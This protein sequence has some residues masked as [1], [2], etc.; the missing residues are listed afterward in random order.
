MKSKTFVVAALTALLAACSG[1]ENPEPRSGGLV[2]AASALTES[3]Q[4][5]QVSIVVTPGGY[6]SNLTYSSADGQFH[7]ALLLPVG[8]YN[9]DATAYADTNYD[10]VL[11]PVGYGSAPVVIF[12]TSTTAVALRL[13]DVTGPPPV[14]DHSPVITSATVSN[15]V[16]RVGDTLQFAVAAQDIDGHPITYN[17]SESCTSGVPS[18][19]SN[20]T[21]DLTAW[22]PAAA[23]LCTVRVDA[24]ANGLTDS[25]VFDLTVYSGG[26]LPEGL[27][28]VSAYFVSHPY[29]SQIYFDGADRTGVYFGWSTWRGAADATMPYEVAPGAVFNFQIWTDA[30]TTPD[31]SGMTDNCGG[32]FALYQVQQTWMYGSWTAPAA[33]ALC[34]VTAS[35]WRDGLR[36]AFPVAILVK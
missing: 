11:E 14:P 3:W 12:E 5:Q 22:T 30:N 23:G 16:A 34:T 20:P 26:S 31:L 24:T 33:P 9:V 4:I 29:V 17:W 13:L 6:A 19:F 25:A 10:G 35:V 7:G 28:Q 18:T 36:D 15:T 1:A 2:L 32:T 8:A 21:G 27:L